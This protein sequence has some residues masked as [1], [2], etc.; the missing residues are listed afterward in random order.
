MCPSPYQKEQSRLF[1]LAEEASFQL[2]TVLLVLENLGRSAEF[3]LSSIRTA[4]Q[5]VDLAREHVES[6]IV[7]GEKSEKFVI[8]ERVGARAPLRFKELVTRVKVVLN[9]EGRKGFSL[10]MQ[11]A[12]A[13]SFA[14]LANDAWLADRIDKPFKWAGL[15][16]YFRGSSIGGQIEQLRNA[17]LI[18]WLNPE[19]RVNT[20]KRYMI[21]EKGKALICGSMSLSA[22][23]IRITDEDDDEWNLTP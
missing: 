21:S 23:P 18:V 16:H 17:E 20:K 11:D 6:H 12:G 1:K 14:L 5:L 10:V 8:P 2:S 9:E 15:K 7:T 22:R 19:E 3:P 4:Q 13:T